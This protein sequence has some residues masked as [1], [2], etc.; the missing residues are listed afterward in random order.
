MIDG[1]YLKELR[2]KHHYSAQDL[3]DLLHVSKATVYRWERENSLRD[4]DL[5][6]ALANLYGMSAEQL[7]KGSLSCE[8]AVAEEP[9]NEE[10]APVEETAGTEEKAAKKQLSL[11]KI[12]A[13]TAASTFTLF[14]IV[15]AIIILCVYFQPK[16]YNNSTLSF[17]FSSLDII[18]II[19]IIILGTLFVATATIITCY[20]I[21]KR[22]KGK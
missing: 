20:L 8:T 18:I 3:A 4:N 6:N 5:I 21:R 2:I 16:S 1:K 19:G 11:V 13:I 7:Y 10:N 22:R 17:A 14:A 15:T 9:E 12:G